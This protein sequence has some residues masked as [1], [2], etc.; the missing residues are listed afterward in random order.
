MAQTMRFFNKVTT[1]DFMGVRKL[2]MGISVVFML[3]SAVVLGVRGLNF[4]L[5]FTGGILLEIGY[6]EAVDLSQIRSTLSKHGYDDAV[7]QNF[8]SAK[9]VIVRLAPRAEKS[10]ADVSNDVLKLLREDTN[11]KAEMRRQEYVGPQIGEELR[12]QGGIA[13]L[14][15]LGSIMLYVI[16][17]FEWRYATGAVVSLIHD[18]IITLGFFAFFQ[19]EFDLTVLAAILAVSGYS[20]NDTIVVADRVRENFIKLRRKEPLEVVNISL[21]ETLSRTT[22]TSLA[23]LLV[24]VAMF[25]WGGAMIHGFSLALIIGIVSGT[26][27]SIYIASTLAIMLKL[28]RS[29]L[30]PV[31]KESAE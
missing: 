25:V 2:A 11:N 1:I 7:V 24:V 13:M 28:T 30:I 17:R 20:L 8:G 18:T 9:D 26:Y 27:S 14:I 22:M 16:M 3:A 4:G 10:N 5:D 19:W 21:N 6:P 29:N 12:D 23:T 15:A 31:Q